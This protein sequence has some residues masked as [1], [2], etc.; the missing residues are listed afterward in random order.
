MRRLAT[1][2]TLLFGIGVLGLL[3]ASLTLW[4]SIRQP[5]LGLD[6]VPPEDGPGLLLREASGPA[7]AI[8]A[9]VRLLSVG[10]A[11]GA[12]ITL[13]ALTLI[14]EPDTLPDKTALHAFRAEQERIARALRSGSALLTWQAA[15]A[16]PRTTAV[17]PL[18][19]RPLADLPPV[20]WVQVLTGF[21][22]LLLGGWVWSLKPTG[23][24]QGFLLLTGLGLA[25]SASAAA[26]YSTRE[27]ALPGTTLALLQ[28]LNAWGALAF[29]AGMIGLFLSYPRRIAPAWLLW[30]QAFVLL[31]W[32]AANILGLIRS[33]ALGFQLP[34][35][36]A[37]LAILVCVMAQRR[38]TRG[39]LPARAALRLF[40]LSIV[41]GAGGFV[42][43]SI[44]PALLGLPSAVSQGYAFALFLVIHVGLASSVLR[45]RLFELERWSFNIL[46]YMGGVALLL[47]LD[48]ILIF[49]VALDRAP[50][51]G[52]S[53][54]VVALIYLP[55]RD[56]AAW[57]LRRG[58]THR[59]VT[60]IV[61]KADGV[62]RA[63][64]A[65]ERDAR[66]EALLR[67]TFEPLAVEPVAPSEGPCRIEEEGVALLVPGVS[68][69]VGKRLRWRE[70]GRRLFTPE[71]IARA[72]EIRAI[73]AQLVEG[74][75][76]FEAGV[77]EER[78]R[79]ARDIHDNIGVHLLGALHSP[80]PRRKD[81]LIRETLSD[82]REIIANANGGELELSEIL[83]DLRRDMAELL[84]A[85]GIALDWPMPSGPGL[86]MSPRMAHALRSV[87]R[88]ALNNAHRHSGAQR[89]TVRVAAQDGWVHLCVS[90]DGRGLPQESAPGIARLNDGRRGNGLDNMR[91]RVEDMG[92]QFSRGPAPGGGLR[93]EAA[94][95]LGPEPA[96][97]PAALQE[98]SAR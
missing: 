10:T 30:A 32:W 42:L 5:W 12:A 77:T 78:A 80:D 6:L 9:G 52:L 48:A 2:T 88:E 16:A 67:D 71:D 3:I 14:E 92:G 84:E 33:N 82:L 8:P 27:L 26:V 51:L 46:Y 76:A 69:I 19:A 23:R 13:S 64:D 60:N 49:A 41:I 35:V 70:G 91:S 44:V 97:R 7:G 72:E 95:P 1:P 66:W 4:L 39:D 74:R 75:Q 59:A 58:R 54:L 56:W 65:E 40:G 28:A 17:T 63:L 38:A 87:L 37:L 24:A 36:V 47:V 81:E 85:S 98:V 79:I 90:D 83:A 15:E 53:L 21:A 93:I 22:G 29:G 89:V 68:G 11:G 57:R 55:A 34:I 94:L 25:V 73:L 61:R 86:T 62:L 31:S 96:R 18:A 50:A 45:Y 20:F 43:T